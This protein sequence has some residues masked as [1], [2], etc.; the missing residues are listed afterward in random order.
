M[1]WIILIGFISQ[2]SFASIEKYS[3]EDQVAL[4]SMGIKKPEKRKWDWEDAVFLYGLSEYGK[5]H[6]NLEFKNKIYNYLKDFQNHWLHEGL[7]SIDRSDA[8]PSALT[9]LTLA[10]DWGDPNYLSNLDPVIYYLKYEPRNTVGTINHLGHSWLR[11]FY[12]ASIWVDSL[13]MIGV[14]SSNIG[15]YYMDYGMKEFAARQPEIFAQRLQDPNTGLFKHAWYEKEDRVVPKRDGFWLR[16]NGWVM[17]SVLKIIE[18]MDNKHPLYQKNVFIFKRLAQSLMNYQRESGFW[19]TLVNVKSSYNETS[20]TAL[21]GWA[22]ARGY[23]LGI[24]GQEALKSARKAYG[25]TLTKIK[26]TKKG[27]SLRGISG[28]TNPGPA[29]SYMVIPTIPDKGYGVGPF[30]MLASEMKSIE[31]LK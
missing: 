17:V 24:L 27:L 23:H 18:E 4:H 19:G 25:A 7:P 10:T 16:G 5:N 15:T 12:P 31:D 1:Y 3:L 21:V 8:C 14:L 30:L 9:A 2:F 22:L 6:G 29:W 13:M 26:R 11:W 28:P 20:G